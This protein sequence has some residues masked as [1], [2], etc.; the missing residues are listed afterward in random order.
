[1]KGFFTSSEVQS[2][3]PEV[4]LV[5]RCGACGLLKQCRSPKMEP[6]GQMRRKVLVVGEA[7]GQTEDEEGRPFIGKAGQFLRQCLR[8]AGVDLDKD[9]IT[10][11]SL[12]CRPPNNRT[13][14]P[15]EIAYCRANL[16]KTIE[17][18]EPQVILTLGR[19][20][21]AS[22]IPLCWKGDVGPLERWVGWR[23]PFA[24]HWI[25]PTYHPS[26]LLRIKNELMDRMF[27]EHLSTAFEI[28]C[29]P[30]KD[31]ALAEKV[32]VLLDDAMVFSALREMHQRGGW[33]AVDY[34]TN[35]IKPEYPK[36]RIVSCAASN[37]KRTISYPW[38]GKAIEGT[39]L[40]LQSPRT[41]KIAS[42]L[43]FEDRW[44]RFHLKADVANWGW[45]TMIAAHCLDNRPNTTSLK[46]QALVQMGVPTYNE[47]VEPYLDV[48][49]RGLYNRIEDI[50]LSTLLLYGGMD[51]ILEYRLALL[52]RKV[53]GYED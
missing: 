33:V 42:N 6:Y 15:K 37:G 25:C 4:G 17:E 39:R 53:L 35:C 40:L 50:D 24:A 51:A 49:G 27:T 2:D 16:I 30:S 32:E 11:N 19:S 14:D 8:R 22:V 5:P 34:E 52:Q 48:R 21:L 44:T 3:R 12:V 18:W 9:A 29:P 20:A 43:K 26:F 23:I 36:A 41:R 46:F 47:N 7:P 28:D 31:P 45:D 13:P 1:M 38:L 10:T